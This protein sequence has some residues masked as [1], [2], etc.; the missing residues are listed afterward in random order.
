MVPWN[1]YTNFS[2][3]T[4]VSW[5]KY[6]LNIEENYLG[7]FPGSF[8]YTFTNKVTDSCRDGWNVRNFSAS[9][10]LI[11]GGRW[12]VQNSWWVKCTKLDDLSEIWIWMLQY[13]RCLSCKHNPNI[14]N[15]DIDVGF[16]TNKKPMLLQLKQH[17]YWSI[18]IQSSR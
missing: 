9:Q 1:L 16:T 15:N 6:L 18:D 14:Q 2:K 12:N 7:V 11:I 10:I 17:K 3:V 13:L 8:I 4:I 5:K